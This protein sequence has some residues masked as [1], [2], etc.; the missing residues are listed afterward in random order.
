MSHQEQKSPA[1]LPV[2]GSRFST[3]SL[4]EKHHLR[5]LWPTKPTTNDSIGSKR[6]VSHQFRIRRRNSM[7]RHRGASIG[8]NRELILYTKHRNP[9]NH[10]KPADNIRENG[11]DARVKAGRSP[12]MKHTAGV[13]IAGEANPI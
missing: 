7:T 1:R 6:L 13:K 12:K 9:G 11:D 4:S 3:R 2:T 8:L 10:Q 5:H